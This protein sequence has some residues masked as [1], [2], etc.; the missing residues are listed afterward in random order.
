MKYAAIAMQNTN[1]VIRPVRPNVNAHAPRNC[2]QPQMNV[3]SPTTGS[4]TIA[5]IMM[6]VS[7]A[8]P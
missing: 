1:A 4:I 6:I 5:A 3:A 7:I 8:P 2:R